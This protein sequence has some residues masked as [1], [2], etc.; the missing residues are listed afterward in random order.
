MW[1]EMSRNPSRNRNNEW[2]LTKSAWSPS[3][4]SKNTGWIF[5]DNILKVKQGDI[6]FH[7]VGETHN[8]QIIGYSTADSN[9]FTTQ[10]I[11]PIQN[12]NHPGPF[13]RVLLRDFTAFKDPVS[14][15]QIFK[16]KSLELQDYFKNNKIKHPAQHEH[17]F[18]VF[19]EGKIRCLNG[20][21]FSNLS[22]NLANLI[23]GPD[24]SGEKN[25]PRPIAITVNTGEQISN[26][27]SR[28]GQ[29]LFSKN[30]KANFG[31]CCC[32]P[33]CNIQ[34]ID[35]LIGA[36]I[37]R[38]V[39]HPELRGDISNGLCLCLFHDKAFEIG[40]FV[41]ENTYNVKINKTKCKNNSWAQANLVPFDG[42]QIKLGSIKPS[43]AALNI[44]STRV[45]YVL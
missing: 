7:L 26:I 24:F 12:D 23:L 22:E 45:K 31:Y 27:K 20:A 16:D 32:F 17:L 41:I 15:D 8:A 18:F 9:G 44:H 11:P 29:Q 14:I 5:W 13:Y 42:R 35:F 28:I 33:D 19:Q 36:H 30:I 1:L 4:T 40:A 3:K 6:V 38:W 21:Y 10:E 2:G 43:L 34:D 37:A 39:D 25:V